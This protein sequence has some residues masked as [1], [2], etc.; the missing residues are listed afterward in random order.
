MNLRRCGGC[1]HR[2]HVSE[3]C[4]QG[5]VSPRWQSRRGSITPTRSSHPPLV[6]YCDVTFERLVRNSA[7]RR[8]GGGRASF[9]PR[10]MKLMRLV[11]RLC[12]EPVRP[13]G[14]DVHYKLGRE[15]N[16]LQGRNG[17]NGLRRV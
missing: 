11:D 3:H 6:K 8:R 14:D 9:S 7:R 4:R 5:V 10:A 12:P 13:S 15:T 1:W 17:G 2:R 16:L